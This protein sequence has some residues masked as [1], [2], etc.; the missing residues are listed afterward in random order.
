MLK[1]KWLFDLSRIGMAL[2]CTFYGVA[3]GIDCQL[4]DTKEVTLASLMS[5]FSRIKRGKARF[6]EM[7]YL[8]VLEE[9]LKIEGTLTYEAT[10]KIIK[11]TLKP[12]R[13][14]LTVFEGAVTIEN[15]EGSKK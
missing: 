4:K 10:G 8:T 1:G 13:E 7:R 11:L 5:K 9:P 15:D 14:K 12:H 3:E 2:L 6:I